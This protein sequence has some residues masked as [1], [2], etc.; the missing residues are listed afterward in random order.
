MPTAEELVARVDRLYTLPVV[1]L[2]VKAVVEDPRSSAQDLTQVVSADPAL[3]ARL[4]RVVNSVH[5]G[6]MRRVDTVASAVTI[7]G[8]QQLHDLVLATSMATVFQGIRPAHMDMARFWRQSVLRGVVAKAAAETGQVMPAQ[9]LFVLGLLAD[10]GHLVM[11]Q[12][13]PEASERALLRAEQEMRPLHEVEKEVIGCHYAEVGAQLMRKWQL[14]E[15]F[16]ETIA[17]Q[18]HPYM[19]CDDC[20]LDAAILQFSWAVADGMARNLDDSAIS[21]R[22]DPFVW[23]RTRLEARSIGPIRAAAEAHYA[24]VLMLIFPELQAAA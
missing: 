4:L 7:L 21:Q 24:E 19:T 22:V 9:R 11:Y 15:Q 1:Y 5:Y 20:S 23:Q 12:A 3:T 17:A 10:I 8:M 6:L 14:P 18:I 13:V 2:R 16:V